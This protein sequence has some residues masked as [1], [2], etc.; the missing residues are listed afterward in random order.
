MSQRLG[1]AGTELYSKRDVERH[2]QLPAAL[3]VV[4]TTYVE[5]ARGRVLNPAKSTMHLGDDGEWPGRDAFSIGMPAYVDWLDVAGMKWAVATWDT[6]TEPPISSQILLFD[7]QRGE[8]TAILEGM[9]ITGVRTALQSVVG[10]R[11]LLAEPPES[12]GV[13]GAGFQARFQL[14]VIDHLVDVGRFRLYDVS[15]GRAADLAADLGPGMAADVVTAD[16]PQ[17]AADADVVVTVTDSKTPVVEES[18]LGSGG[19][20][21]ALGSY[22]ELT[23]GTVLGADR[24]VVDHTEQCLQRG[25]LSDL[26]NRGE[27][28]AAELDSTIGAVL[29]GDN[30]SHAG[31]DERVVFVP[32]GLGSLDVALAEHLRTNGMGG[33]AVRTF[34]FG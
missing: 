16:S 5:G 18:W 3:D 13:F 4:E 31:P 28:T 20:V 27:V 15:E 24:I 2:L 19:L 22:R 30:D 11:H 7:L 32:I 29:N 12:I 17:A 21:I 10:L 25:A 14:R 33:G 34:D 26:A 9:H 1:G 23:D 6:D 8:F